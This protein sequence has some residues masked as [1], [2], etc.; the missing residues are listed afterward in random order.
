MTTL[1]FLFIYLLQQTWLHCSAN[2]RSGTISPPSIRS[3]PAEARLHIEPRS[4]LRFR[5]PLQWLTQQLFECTS[6]VLCGDI[7]NTVVWKHQVFV[8]LTCWVNWR[9][10]LH[11]ACTLRDSSDVLRF[12]LKLQL[13]LFPNRSRSI[14]ARAPTLSNSNHY[15]CFWFCNQTAT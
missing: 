6:A 7:L 10:R 14:K 2:D 12:R 4:R 8:A 11:S 5:K 9:R 13:K 3:L 1:L 15:V